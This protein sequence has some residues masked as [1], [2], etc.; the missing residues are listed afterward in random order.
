MKQGKGNTVKKFLKEKNYKKE[1]TKWRVE[2]K[3]K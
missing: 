3:K 1:E 2:N